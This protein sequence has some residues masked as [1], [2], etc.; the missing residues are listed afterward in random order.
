MI[1]STL[2]P[3]SIILRIIS[4]PLSNLFQKQLVNKGIHPLIVNF[5]TYLAF[6]FLCIWPAISVYWLSLP[7]QFWL[8]SVLA[9][10]FSA[11]GNGFLIKALEKGELSVLGPINAYKPLIG[12]LGGFLLMGE[13][14]G[15]WGLAGIILILYGS[16]FIFDKTEN[17]VSWAIIK[18]PEIQ[19]RFL[20]LTLTAIEAVFVRKVTLL[21]SVTTT[22]ICWCWFGMLFSFFFL[23]FFGI[24]PKNEIGKIKFTDSA[25]L[26]YLVLSS[27][28]MLVSSIYSLN[29]IAVGYALSLFQLSSVG[30]VL[31]GYHFF[32]EKN[33]RRKL[34]GSLVM[35][36]GS[37]MIILSQHD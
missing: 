16:Y 20:A 33:I 17:R 11:C 21:S 6:S 22:T 29:H 26:S 1:Q 23:F 36:I 3:V 2:T 37:I 34:L 35:I 24:N 19:F 15:L 31:L 10:L 12:I 14:P 30:S 13:V 28:I 27:G 5:L 9:G 25:R 7:V 32:N 18:R 8:Y 4:S